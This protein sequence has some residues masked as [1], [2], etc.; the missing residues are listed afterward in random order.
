MY[1]H[2]VRKVSMYMVSHL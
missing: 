1:E 2:M